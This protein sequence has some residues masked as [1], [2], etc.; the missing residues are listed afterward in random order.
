V[1]GIITAVA[2]VILALAQTE[3]RLLLAYSTIAQ[4]GLIIAGLSL[5]CENSFTGSLFH[6]VNH[7]VIKVALFLCA[8]QISYIFGTKDLRKMR[9][10]LRLSPVIAGA[11]ILAILGIIGAPLFS[12]SVSKYLLIYGAAGVFEW[13]II[14]INFGTTLIFVKY[15]AIFFGK[16]PE[17]IRTAERDFNRRAVV[18][19][20]GVVSLLMGIFGAQAVEFL[21]NTPVS[22]NLIGYLE[23]VGIFAM[24]LGLGLILHKRFLAGKEP[25][26]LQRLNG[27]TLSFQKICVSVGVFFAG[28][29]VYV[30]FLQG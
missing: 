15:S 23:K 25:A 21:F 17:D 29:L 28:V 13:V 20:L 24:S 10:A 3:I 2:G 4:V 7:A 26:V 5:G 6:I 11:N 9:G 16:P 22:V 18:L 1:I 19:T 14:I 12:G 27:L 30:G 8:S